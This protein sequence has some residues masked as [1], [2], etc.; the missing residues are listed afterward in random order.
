MFKINYSSGAA[1]TAKNNIIES[2][3]RIIPIKTKYV[4]LKHFL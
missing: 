3:I 4:N 2:I 1:I